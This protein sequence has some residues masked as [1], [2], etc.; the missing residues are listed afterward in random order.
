MDLRAG[1]FWK[2]DRGY[3]KVLAVQP[4]G[5]PHAIDYRRE[6]GSKFRLG[7]RRFTYDFRPLP[8]EPIDLPG[9]PKPHPFG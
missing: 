4:D 7:L 2:D 8:S 1:Q 3:V 5:H 9:P 6:N